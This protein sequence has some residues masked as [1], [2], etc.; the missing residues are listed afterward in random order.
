[1]PKN[2]KKYYQAWKLRKQGK[3]LRE[4]AEIM[5]LSK[6]RVRFM[7]K[8]FDFRLNHKLWKLPKEIKKLTDSEKE[9]KIN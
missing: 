6:E 4:I 9:K 2:L 3:K 5:G 7:T 1:M 8:Y